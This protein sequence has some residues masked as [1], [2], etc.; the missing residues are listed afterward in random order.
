MKH[1][2]IIIPIKENRLFVEQIWS[3]QN[4]SIL[5]DGNKSTK[6][7]KF[8]A[9]AIPFDREILTH[10]AQSQREY[11]FFSSLFLCVSSAFSLFPSKLIRAMSVAILKCPLIDV[12][13]RWQNHFSEPSVN[14]ISIQTRC[15]HTNV[16]F[17]IHTQTHTENSC[18]NQSQ[19]QSQI[20]NTIFILKSHY[21]ANQN[22][23]FRKRSN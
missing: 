21:D 3:S 13:F 1:Q 16:F 19:P 20:E 18:P 12:T 4:L 22:Q 15:N 23:R 6:R 11:V 8:D 10:S 2:K 9:F 5:F 17:P 14:L 7:T